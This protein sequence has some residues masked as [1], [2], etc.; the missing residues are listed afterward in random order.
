MAMR[1]VALLRGINLGRH[2]RIAMADLR[3][4]V[5]GLGYTGVSTHLQSGNILLSTEDSPDEVARAIESV[6]ARKTRIEV[7]VLVRTRAEMDGVVA[8]NPLADVVADA[9]RL[10]VAFL[11]IPPERSWLDEAGLAGIDTALFGLGTRELYI[12]CP[13]GILA[14][15]IPAALAKV[16]HPGLVATSR[17]WRTVIRLHDMLHA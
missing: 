8:A 16:K 4:M 11:S 14:S 2:K 1:H 7:A 5:S 17:N 13:D 9:T 6:I 15:P 10:L 3:A 12:W